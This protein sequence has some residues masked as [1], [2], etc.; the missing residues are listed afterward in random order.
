[1]SKYTFKPYNPQSVALF[2]KERAVIL[3]MFGH[4]VIEHVGSSAVI[5]FGGKGIIDLAVSG[6][7]IEELSRA[8]Y[9]YREEYSVAGR[10]FFKKNVGE[11]VY[12]LHLM[13]CEGE[14][15][16]EMVAFRDRLRSDGKLREQYEALKKEANGDKEEYRRLKR[17]FLDGVL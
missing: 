8:G 14:I 15:W 11:V 12:H 7:T 6:L 17:Q 1:M 2:E 5:G 10:A 3:E 13:E 16:K 9:T 4:A